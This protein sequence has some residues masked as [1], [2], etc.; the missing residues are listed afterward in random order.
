MDAAALTRLVMALL[1]PLS[2]KRGTGLPTNTDDESYQYSLRLY[3]VLHKR[4][5][6]IHDEGRANEALQLFL[7]HP[8]YGFRI[9]KKLFPLLQ[10]D[11]SFASE[12]SSIIEVGPR[13]SLTP[14]EEREA[15]RIRTLNALTSGRQ[16]IRAG[17]YSKLEDVQMTLS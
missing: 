7:E 2:H 17:K 16:E 14:Q 5:A 9:E 3:E 1:A 8:E 6:S 15:G 4:F 13:R 10:A 12:L 11:P